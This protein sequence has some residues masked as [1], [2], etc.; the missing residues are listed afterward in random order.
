[1]EISDIILF[2]ERANFEPGEEERFTFE[3]RA[4]SGEEYCVTYIHEMGDRFNPGNYRL[5]HVNR[6]D[7]DK[8]TPVS[9]DEA[10]QDLTPTGYAVD[11]IFHAELE[12][13]RIK[14]LIKKNQAVALV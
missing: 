10:N 1:M 13:N 6:W 7:D 4:P 2:P 14:E 9:F 11:D 8:C 5:D 12:K 3:F